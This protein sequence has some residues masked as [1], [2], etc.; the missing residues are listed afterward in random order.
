MGA[1]DADSGKRL[2]LTVCANCHGFDGT[3]AQM[4]MAMPKI[5]DLTSPEMHARMKD[6]DIAKLVENGRDKMPAFGT[7]FKPEQMQSLILY[8]RSLKKG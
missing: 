6:D 1:V 4:R 7:M 3:G 5:G 2:F 8:V